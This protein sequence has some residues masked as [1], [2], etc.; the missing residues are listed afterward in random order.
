[1]AVPTFAAIAAI[2]RNHGPLLEVAAELGDPSRVGL[3]LLGGAL[4]VWLAA[5]S[6]PAPPARARIE[7]AACTGRMADL[8]A[9]AQALAF[10]YFETGRATD[11]READQPHRSEDRGF[12]WRDMVGAAI[13]LWGVPPREAWSMT[14][15]E[16]WAAFDAYG[17]AHG[18]KTDGPTPLLSREKARELAA[19]LREEKRAELQAGWKEQR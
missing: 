5:G 13:A 7:Q 2:E 11:G 19:A 1:M 3:S 14:A 4:E 16:W 6:S 12:P 15:G 18:T 17:R 10:A 9:D 8:L